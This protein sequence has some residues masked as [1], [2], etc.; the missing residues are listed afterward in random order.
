MVILIL[1]FR[2]VMLNMCTY[3]F[4]ASS[5]CLAASREEIKYLVHCTLNDISLQTVGV[6]GE[7]DD[8]RL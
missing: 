4:T 3:Y 6:A 8:G 1:S 7:G 2:A 5:I